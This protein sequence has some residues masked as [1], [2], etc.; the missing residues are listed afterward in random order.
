M[1]KIKVLIIDDSA[2]IRKYIKDALSKSKLIDVVGTAPDPV[3]GAEKIK[4]Y[5]PD[6][7]TLDIEMPKMDGITFLSKL[8]MV[9]PMPVVMVS[10]LTEKGAKETIKALELGAVDV[11]LKPGASDGD[12][13]WG[14]FSEEL[15]E[16]VINASKANITKKEKRVIK[17][18]SDEVIGSK[19][20]QAPSSFVL[21]IG[22]STGGTEV[23]SQIISALPE[24]FPAILITQ[25]MPAKFTKAFA[26]RINSY[27][28][29]YVKEAEPGDRVCNGCVYIAPGGTQML[30]KNRASGGYFI[31]VN[32]DPPVNRHKPS[33]DVLF[34]SVVASAGNSSVGILLTGMGRD[35][36]KGLLEMNKKGSFT[37]AQDEA[38]SCVFGMPREAIELGAADKIKN[39][40]GIIKLLKENYKI[41]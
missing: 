16:K 30:L 2:V 5:K 28:A 23:I 13:R 37:I 6:L 27:S 14:S 18:L 1:G 8:M 15:I 38:S 39:I 32:D 29:M 22:A 12:E 34:N 20:P 36:A 41:E 40:E 4:K 26:D 7:I 17:P 25:H 24:N 21:A 33:V 10:T 9:K 11:V 31:E 35:G 3:F 19:E